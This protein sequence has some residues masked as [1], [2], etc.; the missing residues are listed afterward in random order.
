MAWWLDR[1]RLSGHS[2]LSSHRQPA[3][4]FSVP[5]QRLI[6]LCRD[7]NV[8]EPQHVYSAESPQTATIAL[9]EE[10]STTV[11]GR[12]VTFLPET[13][14]NLSRS[15]QSLACMFLRSFTALSLPHRCKVHLLWQDSRLISTII[16]SSAAARVRDR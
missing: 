16:P 3:P 14:A 15:R 9:E 10:P 13:P 11:H 7:S 4:Y 5:H 12:F 2:T 6:Y 8:L 1:Q